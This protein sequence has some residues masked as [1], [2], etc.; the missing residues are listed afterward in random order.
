MY[1]YDVEDPNDM[2]LPNEAWSKTSMELFNQLK[3][4]A[5]NSNGKWVKL[6]LKPRQGDTRLFTRGVT[7]H[8]KM[9]EYAI[10]VNK[11]EEKL[12]GVVQ[13]GPYTEGPAGHVHG[14]AMATLLDIGCGI[15]TNA[16]GRRAVTANLSINYKVSLPLNST[17]LLQSKIDHVVGRKVYSFAEL[18]SADGSI[19]YATATAL[20]IEINKEAVQARK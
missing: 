16:S 10:F 2:Y 7:E 4:E 19:L 8:G 14:G 5:E 18:K 17:V 9:F 3:R 13:C 6:K 20:F 12:H 1:I 15:L 11:S